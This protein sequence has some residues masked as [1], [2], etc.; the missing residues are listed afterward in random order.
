MMRSL[1]GLAPAP[2]DPASR[3]ASGQIRFLR[4]KIELQLRFA[5]VLED[6][7]EASR[8]ALAELEAALED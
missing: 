2:H 7:A 8:A 5:R 4:R 3:D 1:A 6:H